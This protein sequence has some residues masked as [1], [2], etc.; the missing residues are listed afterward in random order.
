MNFTL[1]NQV[2]LEALEDLKRKKK[3]IE[4]DTLCQQSTSP[5]KLVYIESDL[6]KTKIFVFL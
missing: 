4:S 1:E 3:E 5:S 6:L 2:L